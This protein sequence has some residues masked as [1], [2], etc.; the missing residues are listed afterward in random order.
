MT[1]SRDTDHGAAEARRAMLADLLRTR[2]QPAMGGGPLSENQRA[3]WFLRQLAPTSAAYN[4]AFAVS[5]RS[6]VN[7]EAL[8][9]ALQ[10]LVDRH[11]ALRTTYRLEAGAPVQVVHGHGPSGFAHVE[12][13]G[14]DDDELRRRVAA[15]I[16]EPFDLE[17]GPVSRVRLFT[18]SDT[19]HVLL[20]SFHHIAF[21][22][23]SMWVFLDELRYAYQ[24]AAAGRRTSLPPPAAEYRDF[25][26][27]QAEMLASERGQRARRHWHDQLAG[28]LPVL[29]LPADR[30][31]SELRLG[32]VGASA[33]FFLSQETVD[34]AR[35]FARTESATLY[36][37]LL[38]A[39]HVLIHHYTGQEVVLVGSPVSGRTDSEFSDVVG[40]FVNSIVVRG[41]L[42]GA[43]TFRAFLRQVRQAVL[44]ALEH[45]DYPFR[46][47]TEELRPNRD[48]RRPPLFQTDFALHRPHRFH[49]LATIVLAHGQIE[50]GPIDFG[51]LQVEYYDVH[52]QGG[53]LDL[54]VEM[55]ETG[56]DLVGVFRYDP[57][58]FELETIRRMIRHYQLLVDR[59]VTDPDSPVSAISLVAED[60]RQRMLVDWNATEAPFPDDRCVH[61]LFEAQ[62]ERTPDAV[63]VI[64]PGRA[65]PDRQ[66]L[67]YR[68]LNGLASHLAHRLRSLGVGPDVLVGLCFGRSLEMLVGLLAILKAGGAYLPLDLA[69]PQERVEGI[70]HD[71]RVGVLL[72]G[73]DQAARFTAFPGEIVGVDLDADGV[74][75]LPPVSSRPS[76]GPAALAYVVYT[77]G[78]SGRPKGVMIEHRALVNYVVAAADRFALTPSDRVLQF[79]SLGFDTAAEEIFPCLARGGTLL[80]RPE[81]IV[82]TVGEFLE[83]SARLGLTV[84]DL[85]T[86]YWHQLVEELVRTGSPLPRSLRLVVIG[87]E[88]ALPERVQAWHQHVGAGVRLLNTYGPT[89][90][91]IVAL[92]SELTAEAFARD[93]R[94]PI[95]RPGPNVR[96]YVLDTN[97][98]PVAVGVVG[99]LYIGGAG[100]ARGYLNDPAQTATRFVANPIG[101]LPDGRRVM[102]ARLYRTGDLVRYRGDGNLEFIGRVDEQAKIRGVRVEVGEV[103]AALVEHAAVREAAVIARPGDRGEPSLVAYVAGTAAAMPTAG[104]LREFL[105]RRLPGEMVPATLVVLDALPRTINGKIDRRALPAPAP[106]TAS[107]REG[108]VAPRTETERTVADIYAGVLGLDKVGVHDGFFE[109]GGHSL[110]ATRAITRMR[111]TFG[112]Q[113][114]VRAIFEMVT[115]AAM[116]EHVEGLRGGGR[117]EVV[118]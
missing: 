55:L 90:A 95:G 117:E 54:S 118:L 68:E 28:D 45:Q 10:S 62:V 61:E 113:V 9:A 32:R 66:R 48:L 108:Y 43:P 47:L 84:W 63:A 53:Q 16:Q 56:R 111:E 97:Q 5:I 38:A 60:E 14:W 33:L 71:A 22:G 26:R 52:Q 77:S 27:W 18:R 114:Q 11:A 31:R 30:S 85:P 82:P 107:R 49:E 58:L 99:E 44:G 50:G 70:L 36:V 102:D 87:G 42:G 96:V 91:T 115:V 116:A 89:E 12:A 17:N 72:A 3:M 57:D 112:V 73:R 81:G 100:V 92:T 64:E 6:V 37:A 2:A 103:E 86:A 34:R 105:R 13:A 98:Q 29:N 24:A 39:Y 78:S 23:W 15:A 65:S 94:V 40:C 25:V 35:A 59:L 4:I 83:T 80:L 79:A 104:E 93:G 8:A 76:V 19:A 74:A 110:T 109:L 88:R 101:S 51:D 46:R 69:H 1:G 75:S 106:L 67:T 41:D 21:D 20:L 7:V